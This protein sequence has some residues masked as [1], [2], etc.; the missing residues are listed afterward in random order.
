MIHP[1]NSASQTTSR[2]S[3]F[4]AAQR[5]TFRSVGVAKF[6]GGAI[7]PKNPEPNLCRMC[8]NN[9]LFCTSIY[10]GIRSTH[11]YTHAEGGRGGAQT[12]WSTR[13]LCHQ[14]LGPAEEVVDGQVSPASSASLVRVRVGS[15]NKIENPQLVVRLGPVPSR[16]PLQGMQ[17][18]R[19]V[20]LFTFC[21]METL[22]SFVM[23][24]EQQLFRTIITHRLRLKVI[25]DFHVGGLE[26]LASGFDEPHTKGHTQG[27]ENFSKK[28]S[29]T[30]N[31]IIFGAYNIITYRNV[32]SFERLWVRPA[33]WEKNEQVSSSACSAEREKSSRNVICCC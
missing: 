4:F 33:R 16:A 28:N 2:V 5:N 1:S 7:R 12:H 14:L 21:W 6:G 11:N 13:V 17:S 20:A 26:Q 24:F 15:W 25:T 29:S 27:W 3:C 8:P 31:I 32:F 10:I 23:G 9:I 19:Q 18:S 22:I 30:K